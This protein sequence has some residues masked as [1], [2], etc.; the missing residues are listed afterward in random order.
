MLPEPRVDRTGVA[1]RATGKPETM[2]EAL[3][4]ALAV[5]DDASVDRILAAFFFRPRETN[6]AQASVHFLGARREERRPR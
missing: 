6:G 1:P 2:K 5:E 3:E 4:R